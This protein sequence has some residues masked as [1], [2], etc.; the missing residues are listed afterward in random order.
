MSKEVIFCI[1][2]TPFSI[3]EHDY[4][5]IFTRKG[6]NQIDYKI[7]DEYD[8]SSI[9]NVLKKIGYLEI[10]D[11]RFEYIGNYIKTKPSKKDLITS[12]EM[13]GV[14]YNNEFEFNMSE[15]LKRISALVNPASIKKLFESS[16]E[17]GDENTLEKTLKD[18]EE[19]SHNHIEKSNKKRKTTII[20]SIGK[21]IELS[22]YLLFDF[23][24]NESVKNFFIDVNGAFSL[25]QKADK[26]YRNLIKIST[27]KF[28][29]FDNGDISNNRTMF[30]K[31]KKTKGDFLNEVSFLHEVVVDLIVKNKSKNDS[32]MVFDKREFYF[33]IFD[34][35]NKVNHSENIIIS[36][37]ITG[38]ED[39]LILSEKIQKEKSKQQEKTVNIE[40][41]KTACKEVEES[42]TIRMLKKADEDNFKEAAYLKKNIQVVKG[43]IQ[44]FK[45]NHKRGNLSLE[46]YHNFFNLG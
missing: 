30:F 20:P 8:F 45:K 7:R 34:I 32:K 29:R 36:L 39:M 40:E 35:K 24:Y 11:L 43:K 4:T 44:E 41:V 14:S 38:Y 26:R 37:D 22:F 10:D 42:L 27:E 23:V 33:D 1:I 28:E 18:L 12:L 31:S 19:T 16:F 46:D 25:Q 6:H 5:I 3:E 13:T 9:V 21:E 15:E 2:D 17:L